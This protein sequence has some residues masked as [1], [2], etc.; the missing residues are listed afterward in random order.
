[1]KSFLSSLRQIDRK[2]SSQLNSHWSFV[3]L[4]QRL[5]TLFGAT[6]TTVFLLNGLAPAQAEGSK[7]LIAN[8]GN[9]AYLTYT[10]SNLYS[11]VLERTTIYVYAETGENIN[12]GSSANGFGSGKI[13][14]TK[15]NSSTSSNCL[16]SSATNLTGRIVDRSQEV[17]GPFPLAGGYTPC[18]VTVGSG[19]SGIWK[20][21]FVSPTPNTL[22]GNPASI[23]AAANWLPQ[24]TTNWF[25][26]AWDVTVT[27][28]TIPKI[29]RAYT[30]YFAGN[31]SANLD[32]AFFGIFY[33]VTYDGYHYKVQANGLDPFRFVFFSDNKGVYTT[34]DNKPTYR[35]FAS[36]PTPPGTAFK[37]PNTP[38][39]SGRYT[40]KLFFNEIDSSMPSSVSSGGTTWLNPSIVTPPPPPLKVPPT[41]LAKVS[42]AVLI[43]RT[44]ILSVDPIKSL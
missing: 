20:I 43:L 25:V 10:T 41:R 11:G 15:P 34:V 42:E 13:Q 21:D 32:N 9:R 24:A 44:L 28:G 14:Y 30:N 35:S 8:G 3:A 1:M 17:A 31:I 22:S 6:V 33:V 12:L 23:S 19:E 16:I 26:T 7:E 5:I 18:V 27:K 39:G 36:L 2:T 40:N 4:R 38:D 29:G 37:D